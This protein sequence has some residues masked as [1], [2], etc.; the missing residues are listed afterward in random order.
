MLIA[1]LTGGLACGKSFV[2]RAFA[3]LGCHV[4]EADEL[5]HQVLLPGGEAYGPA[6]VL[7]GPE[8][9]DADGTINRQRLGRIVF[10]DPGKLAE[11]NAIVHPAVQKLA[12]RT[13]EELG[14]ADPNG[15]GI[16]VAAI[17]IETGGW[18]DY[19]KLI[20]VDCSRETQMERA[21]ERFGAT[22]ED[23][24]ARLARQ[25][26]AEKK[27]EVADFVIDTNGTKEETLRQTK[28]VFEQL[29]ISH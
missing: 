13:F 21:G 26:P 4:V 29:R 11:L 28:M 7:F 12:H 14:N 3:D 5:G 6:V 22:P 24:A 1:G 25:L 8:I 9:L 18:R 2:A 15:I 27:R 17:L 19:D 20:V 10:A 16:Y 23:V